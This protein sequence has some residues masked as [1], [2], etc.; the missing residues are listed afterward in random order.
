MEHGTKR[1]ETTRHEEMLIPTCTTYLI[2]DIISRPIQ[3]RL[4]LMFVEWISHRYWHVHNIRKMLLLPRTELRSN[5]TLVS[6]YCSLAG[7]ERDLTYESR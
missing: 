1:P 3:P 6:E 7:I 4:V 2:H 5:E